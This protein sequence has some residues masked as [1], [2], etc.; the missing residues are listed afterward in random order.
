M[1]LEA[2][3]FYLGKRLEDDAPLGY[4]SERLTTHGVIVGMTGSGK[5][6][7]GLNIIEE[8]LLNGVST[9]VIDP[10]GDMGNLLLNYP[11]PTAEDLDEW[12][13]AGEA[14]Q[15]GI[16]IAQLAGEEAAKLQRRMANAGIDAER[17][18][19]LGDSTEMTIYTPGSSAGVGLNIIGSLTPPNLDWESQTESIRAE[20]ESFVSSL[21]VLAG[22]EAD[23]ISSREHILLST[24]IETFWREGREL[25]LATLVGQV[26]N[27]PIRKLGVFDIDDFFPAKARAALAMRLNGLL[28][29]PSFASW[30]SGEP[31][32]IEAMLGGDSTKAAVVY[33]AHLGEEER[34][35]MVTLILSKVVTWFRSL[36]GSDRLRALVYM[37][38]VFGYV[39]PVAE[40]PSKKPILTILKQA[41]AF[42]V[43]MVL[44]TQ[45]PVDLDYKAVS[46]AGTWMIGRLQTETDKRRMLEGLEVADGGSSTVGYSDLISSLGKR[47]FILHTTQKREPVL[48]KARRSM[49]YRA[50]PFTLDQV[51]TLMADRKPEPSTE[52]ITPPPGG[53]AGLI[54][55]SV[56]VM[57]RVADG[58]SA[59]F[60]DPAAPWAGT[61]GADLTST[62]YQA[63]IAATVNLL[64]D[65]ARAGITHQEAYEAVVFP[66]AAALGQGS[67][68]AV[69]HDPRDFRDSP[70]QTATGFVLP[71]AK[72]QNKTYWKSV[73]SQL[74]DHLVANR[75]IE[76]S[77]NADLKLYSRVGET[78]EEF[79][80]RCREAAES[81]ADQALAKLETR[82]RTRIDRVRSTISKSENRVRDLEADADAKGQEELLSGAGDLL[83][84]L[85]GGRARSN[86]L[87][88]AAKRRS[89]TAKARTRADTAADRLAA[90]RVELETLEADLADEISRVTDEHEAKA[91]SIERVEI[92]LEKTDIN[93][94]DL[95]L[96][97]IPVAET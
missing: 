95:K 94:V 50:G 25:D 67:V 34:Q 57:P 92:P 18:R 58:I 5:T 14:E 89:A 7:L 3:H 9:L 70:A 64:Y 51:A 47:E 40:P 78:E 79:L 8:A 86:P 54:E 12:V 19:R 17:V 27:P 96:V 68:V 66:L 24:L 62:S 36:Q 38:E 32:D 28:A 81:A 49:S 72:I 48:F 55:D 16:T 80:A 45:N 29:S 88:Q 33:L 37:D 93:V 60:L 63:A 65:D 11:E 20:I 74:K 71:D 76:V 61:I 26:P 69:D 59:V 15:Q 41:R 4:D 56:P 22:V 10:K 6:G 91:E 75:K 2:N 1:E 83:G 39:P 90:D 97:W 30:I 82:Y 23:P 84:A 52:I 44:V 35:F 21:L 73:A 53:V 85:L 77:K 43:G 13:D 31:L 46:N 87:G 42:G